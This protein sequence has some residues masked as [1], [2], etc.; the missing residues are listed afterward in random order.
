MTKAVW[1]RAGLLALAAALV[2][3]GGLAA[4]DAVK[5]AV[6]EPVQIGGVPAQPKIKADSATHVQ[7]GEIK[8]KGSDGKNTLQ[9]LSIDGEG[10]ILALVAPPRNFGA[11]IKDAAGEVQVFTPDGKPVKT[12]KVDFHANSITAGPGGKIYVAGDGKIASFDRDGKELAKL[13]L[14]HIAELMKDGGEMK[15]AA[16]AQIQAQKDSFEK[17]RKNIKD[18]KEKIEAKKAED[19]TDLEKRQFQ[20]FENILKSYEQSAKYYDDLKVDTILAQQTAR[21]RTING[22]A[23]NDK[24]LFLVCGETKG[25]GYAVWRMGLDF[26][27]PKQVLSGIGGCC[28]QMDLQCCGADIVLAENTKHSWARY[29]RDGKELLRAGKRGTDSEGDCFGGCC[30]PMNTCCVKGDIYTAESEG[31]VKRYSA[32]GKY[33]GLVGVASLQGGCKNVAVAATPDGEKVYFCD[34]P[35]SKVIILGK[36]PAEKKG[37]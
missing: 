8:V 1:A 26:K 31:I 30:N 5:T 22:V 10:R 27:E 28:G 25:Y 15:K 2:G 23:V 35:G 9:T 13:E 37:E 32:D 24:E 21:L 12:F 7:V 20:Q 17:A 19:R 4:Q 33:K 6:A 29:D 18:Q 11:P 36:K 16:E 34:Q 3:V 14:P